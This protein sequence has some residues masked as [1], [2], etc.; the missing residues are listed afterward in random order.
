MPY[1][2]AYANNKPVIP[3][4]STPSLPS[5]PPPSIASSADNGIRPDPLIITQSSTSSWK[6]LFAFTRTAHA[7]PLLGAL[8]ASALAAGFKVALAV[9]LGQVFNIISDYASGER[10]GSSTVNLVSRWSLTMLGLGV[11]NWITHAVF[12]ALWVAFGEIQ[13]S[14]VREETFQSLLSKDMSWFDSQDQGVSSLLARI[15]T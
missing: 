10:S 7:G 8:L 6:D 4:P 11:G 15:Q 14:A 5:S 13:A 2:P 12:I 9:I 3:A 1:P